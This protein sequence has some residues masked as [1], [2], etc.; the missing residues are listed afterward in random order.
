MKLLLCQPPIEDFYSTKERTYPLGLTYL[1][2]VVKD[3]S[4]KV[5]IKD[6]LSVKKR[7]TIKIPNNFEKLKIHYKYDKSEI[8]IF[9]QYYHFGESW[10]NIKIFFESNKFDIVGISSLFYTYTEETIQ[11]AKIIKEAQSNTIVI[12]GGQNVTI[13]NRLLFESADIDFM[14][15]SEGES[16]FKQFVEAKL[17]QNF[18]AEE[19]PNLFYKD[20]NEWKRSEIQTNPENNKFDFIPDNLLLDLENY[21]IQGK[22][23]MMLNTTR[24]CPQGCKF[25]S[26]ENVF[27]KKIRNK[28]YN[29]VLEELRKAK[30]IGIKVID[31]EDDNF[32]KNKIYA[33]TLMKMVCDEFGNYF[34]FYAMNGLSAFDLDNELLELMKK[35]GFKMIN[36]SIATTSEISLK[37]MNRNSSLDKFKDIVERSA[38]LNMKTVGYFIAG[39]PGE[40]VEEILFTMKF[41]TGLPLILGISPFYYIPDLKMKIPNIPKNVKDARLT[42]FFPADKFLNELDLITLFRITR[43]INHVKKLMNKSNL[44]ELNFNELLKIFSHDIIIEKF[45]NEKIIIGIDNNNKI[46]EHQISKKV[47]ESFFKIFENSK[48]VKG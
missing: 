35:I 34:D 7:N 32:T 23:S 27:G 18:S 38:S 44:Q 1:A 13:S 11:L 46:Y 31:I 4:V 36:L 29:L 21:K 40:N 6:F 8:K 12:V 41:L 5:K 28:P 45:I 24:G 20:D 16:P 33:K 48:F 30:E 25:C 37:N 26:I 9:N 10:E 15:S 17:N 42:R 2:G 39:L 22:N 43:I 3:L 19:I 14:F 47:M